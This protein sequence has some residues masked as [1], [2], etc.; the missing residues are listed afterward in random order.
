ML[1]IKDSGDHIDLGLTSSDI[2]KL[3]DS[4]IGDKFS[5]EDASY[6]ANNDFPAI[7]TFDV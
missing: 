6:V 7:L 1:S 2:R 3:S 5:A 4:S